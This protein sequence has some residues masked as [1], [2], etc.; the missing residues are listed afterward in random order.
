[1]IT[2]IVTTDSEHG[3][4][5]YER[6]PVHAFKWHLTR[7]GAVDMTVVPVEQRPAVDA[8]DVLYQTAIAVLQGVST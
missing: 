5:V 8:R 1:M 7:A 4:F 2:R 3:D 6:D